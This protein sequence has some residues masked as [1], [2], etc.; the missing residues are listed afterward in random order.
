M[1]SVCF[2]YVLPFI[3]ND[4]GYTSVEFGL[5]GGLIA[6]TLISALGISGSQLSEIFNK[7]L[8]DF[9]TSVSESTI[10]EIN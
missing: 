9:S 7:I 3:K 5:I 4:D 2:R 10:K 6:L 8:S 1:I